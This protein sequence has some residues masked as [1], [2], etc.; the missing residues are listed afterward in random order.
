MVMAEPLACAS[1]SAGV[2]VRP[3]PPAP[4]EPTV[5]TVTVSAEA[6]VSM[7]TR[8]PTTMPVLEAYLMFVAPAGAAADEVVEN[9]VTLTFVS[10]AADADARVVA[11]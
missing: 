5:V 2:K 6:P 7:V 1:A 11:V 9:P 4:V 8:L 3:P 10:P